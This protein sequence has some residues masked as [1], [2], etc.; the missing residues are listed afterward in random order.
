MSTMY[1]FQDF[2]QAKDVAVFLNAAIQAHKSSDS[3]KVA[4]SADQYDRQQN[5]TISKYIQTVFSSTGVKVEDF[6]AANNRIAS[7]FFNRLN[8][9]RVMYSL[10]NGISFIQ[11]E[12]NL[13]ADDIK[14]RMGENF[15]E[16]ITDAA[17]F[18]CIHGVSFVFWNKDHCHVFK[19]TEFVPLYD[20]Y[21]GSLKAGIRFWQLAE[22]KPT[23]VTLYRE[24]GYSDWLQD[25]SWNLKPLDRNGEFTDAEVIKAY[26]TTT[27][28]IPAD[29]ETMVVGEENYGILP[30]VPMWASRL[31]Q[32]TLIG[33]RAAIDAYDLIRSGFA[34]DMQDCAMVYWIVNNAGGMTE[35]ELAKFRDKIKFQHIVTVDG[36]EGASVVPYTQDIPHDARVA[37]LEEIRKGI[38][39]DFG[40]LDVHTVAAGATNDHIDAA[41][42]PLDENASDLEYWVGRCV[43]Q[44]LAIQGIDDTPEFTRQRISNIKEQV[45]IVTLES[46]WLDE[47]TILR[48][49]PNIS[50]EEASV[51]LQRNDEE[52]LDRFGL[53]EE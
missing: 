23:H 13:H 3:Y 17:Y 41:Y 11:P 38:Y 12:E 15:D 29:D 30:I 47:A 32:S 5:E 34:N 36:T 53:V 8:T 24:D 42:Q 25:K 20:E 1:T 43:K 52:L 22:N 19:L 31:K 46:Q 4:L 37:F 2:E 28:Y 33:M 18:A 49:L 40:G 26:I 10:G 6:T 35:S 50:D 45:E 7:N 48:K 39:E 16:R 21:T 27:A 9:Q 44:L 14:F 51:I